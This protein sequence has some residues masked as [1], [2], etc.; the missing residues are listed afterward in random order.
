MGYTIEWHGDDEDATTPEEVARNILNMIRESDGG[1][2][3]FM[4]RDEAT[5]KRYRVDLG[6]EEDREGEPVV[7]DMTA[8]ELEQARG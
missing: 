2:H 8:E 7:R 4:V 6:T 3:I 1:C 5:G